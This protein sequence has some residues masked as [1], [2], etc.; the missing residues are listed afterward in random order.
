MSIHMLQGEE[1][2]CLYERAKWEAQDRSSRRG[3]VAFKPPNGKEMRNK[4][5]VTLRFCHNRQ[6]TN[7]AR[8]RERE[9]E[10]LEGNKT[11]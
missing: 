8:E 7:A 9:R 6:L 1:G 11:P 4:E 2:W 3:N 5:I 10:R